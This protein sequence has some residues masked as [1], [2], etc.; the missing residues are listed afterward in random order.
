[1]LKPQNPFALSWRRLPTVRLRGKSEHGG[2]PHPAPFNALMPRLASALRIAST[3]SRSAMLQISCLTRIL[4]HRNCLDGI[5][6]T[7]QRSLIGPC[8]AAINGWSLAPLNPHS[9]LSASCAA[10]AGS[11]PAKAKSR[12]S[13][14]R[15]AVGIPARTHPP[16]RTD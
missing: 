3:A 7:P 13:V 1:M 6:E 10:R 4:V 16:E 8:S 2:G 15:G 12:R 11:S 14:A 9:T 5:L